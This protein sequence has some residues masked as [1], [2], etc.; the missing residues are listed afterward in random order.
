MRSQEIAQRY[1]KALFQLSSESSQVEAALNQLREFSSAVSK[2]SDTDSFFTG[3]TVSKEEQSKVLSE[4]FQ[5]KT[6]TEDVKGL[7]T[8]LVQK[9]RFNYL[10]DIVGEFQSVV[11][12]SK[13]IAR[14][15]VSSAAT[16]SPEE[17]T[18]LEV[19]I[20]KY[21]GKKV[22]L[23]YHEDNKLVGGLVAKV[24]SFTFD[25][26]IETQLRLMKDAIKKRRS[27]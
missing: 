12:A 18:S 27:N 19:T 16:L 3:P 6:F 24:G 8:I 11:D 23:E 9:R 13:G 20:S 4:M 17:R 5:K 25:D 26:S 14:G 22:V 1:A 21:T 2:D 10:P 7:L 15:E